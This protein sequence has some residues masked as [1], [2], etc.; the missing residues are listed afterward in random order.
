MV[1]KICF[2]SLDSRSGFAALFFLF[3]AKDVLIL[4]QLITTE[5]LSNLCVISGFRRDVDEIYTLL[6]YYAALSGCYAQT[7]RDN[8]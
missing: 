8:L 3:R 6:G 4:V 7:F 1:T 5:D 2:V